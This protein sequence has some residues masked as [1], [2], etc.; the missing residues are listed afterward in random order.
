[1]S[2]LCNQKAR[3][4]SSHW[5]SCLDSI[6]AS[7][8]WILYLK[9]KNWFTV[10]AS[11]SS[12]G[13]LQRVR[14]HKLKVPFSS[15]NW[16]VFSEAKITLLSLGLWLPHP[17][18]SLSRTPPLLSGMTVQ[19]SQFKVFKRPSFA[20]VCM[21]LGNITLVDSKSERDKCCMTSHIICGI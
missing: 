10:C 1:M 7:L 16:P 21:D 17:T 5:D 9:K 18:L 3:L 12:L 11:L 2:Y 6:C 4:V 14:L 19:S 15:S 13:F 8:S 20:A